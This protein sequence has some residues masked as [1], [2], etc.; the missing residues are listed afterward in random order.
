MPV[1]A[2]FKTAHGTIANMK[3]V[4]SGVKLDDMNF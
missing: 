2:A 4:D 3:T 1:G